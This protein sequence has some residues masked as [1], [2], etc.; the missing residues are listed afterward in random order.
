MMKQK[1]EAIGVTSALINKITTT[2]DGGARLTL[3]LTS[4]DSDIIKQLIDIKLK[5]TGLIVVAF[6]VDS[7]L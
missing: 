3:D 1:L 4:L 2:I 6:S 5:G 7:L